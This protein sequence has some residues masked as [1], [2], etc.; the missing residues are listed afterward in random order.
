M[1]IVLKFCCFASFWVGLRRRAPNFELL[2]D[3]FLPDLAG[4]KFGIS[5]A[6]LRGI[7]FDRPATGTFDGFL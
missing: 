7:T 5:V 1:I 2:D 4:H 6:M 3:P